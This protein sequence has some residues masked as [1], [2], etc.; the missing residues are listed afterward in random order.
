MIHLSAKVSALAFVDD[1]A[2]VGPGCVVWQFASVLSGVTLGPNVSIGAYA[3]IGRGT[4]VGEGSRISSGVF[5]PSNSVIGKNCFL[6]PQVVATDDRR[7]RANNDNYVTEPPT[8]EDNCSV[9]ARSV[10]LPGVKIGARSLTGAGSV[11]TKDVPPDTLVYG[12]PAR[13]RVP[14]TGIMNASSS[15]LQKHEF[16]PLAK[17]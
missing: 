9:G 15:T 10:I 13:E 6:G 5:L 4:A 8:F 12:E 1:T 14:R 17:C 7:P 3:E 11:I 16:G 2:T